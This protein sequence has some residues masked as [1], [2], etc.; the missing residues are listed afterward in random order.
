MEKNL[1][2]LGNVPDLGRLVAD[3]RHTRVKRV[4]VDVP[5][6]MG[7][8]LLDGSKIVRSEGIPDGVSA[9]GLAVR[10]LDNGV[11][12]IEILL[13]HPDFP[14]VLSGEPP[15]LEVKI[16]WQPLVEAQAEAVAN[17]AQRRKLEK[18]SGGKE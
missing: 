17:R 1:P 14:P 5:I 8:L 2:S 13:H 12:R 3:Q 16:H 18:L 10:Q 4:A 11:A 7:L 9:V 6:L 15:F